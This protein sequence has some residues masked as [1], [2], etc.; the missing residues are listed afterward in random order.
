M[1]D[2]YKLLCY[3]DFVS[4]SPILVIVIIVASVISILLVIRSWLNKLEEKSK[5]SGE[6]V[7][8]LKQLSTRMEN[9]SASSD[10]KLIENMKIFNSRL[11]RTALI[12][13]EVQKNIGEVSEIG[14]SMK[15][16]QDLLQSP[17]LR[18]NIGEHILKELLGQ[19]LPM[20]SFSLQYTFKSGDKVDAIIK[21]TQGIIPI[22]SKF[23]LE[24]FR[25]MAEAP[26]LAE[27]DA[28]K[29]EF[30]R[31]VKKHVLDIS[32][33]YILTT[34]GTV[35]YALMYIPSEAI[36]YEIINDNDLFDFVGQH[37]VLPV[38]PLCFYAYLRAILM[39]FEGQR[40]QSQA[41]EILMSLAAMRKD[42][43][44][45]E[46]QVSLL[47]KHVTNAYNQT[48]QVTNMVSVL[49]QKL[50]SVHL[51]TKETTEE[52]LIDPPTI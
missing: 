51:L 39:S 50:N 12:M 2:S 6:L 33:K 43:E 3:N 24:N 9:S 5:V 10:Q 8:W 35:D 17:K 30:I 49:G 42:Y 26:T 36:Y 44:K 19:Y 45:V 16:L 23:P 1:V 46:T 7:E 18:G 14:R 22:D 13:S 31:N 41:K 38:S 11:D 28:A 27:K 4:F 15:D 47:N 37:R 29:K 48:S 52:K 34:E 40:I 20:D 32:K 21:T 25:K